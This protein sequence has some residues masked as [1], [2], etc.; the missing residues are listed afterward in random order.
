M[1]TRNHH[2]VLAESQLYIINPTNPSSTLDDRIEHRLHIRR[3]PADNAQHFG[4]CR[5]MLQRLAQFGVAL[6]QF[7]EEAHVFNCD[8]GLVGESFEKG[9]LFLG[10]G[11]DLGSADRDQ[12]I[13]TSSRISGV[14]RTE[15]VPACCMG[16][17]S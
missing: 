14:A 3:R 7:F 5:L 9:D 6:L 12:P 13:A 17:A 1:S 16:S 11:T 10:E 2:L 15:R 4:R 8:D